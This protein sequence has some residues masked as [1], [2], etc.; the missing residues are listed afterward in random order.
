MNIA[1]NFTKFRNLSYQ[2]MI[3]RQFFFTPARF[4]FSE[5]L[6]LRNKNISMIFYISTAP[7]F[8]TFSLR[9]AEHKWAMKKKLRKKSVDET[10]RPAGEL[11]S[12]ASSGRLREAERSIG[13]LVSIYLQKS[14]SIQPRTS[15]KKFARSPYTDRPGP[16]VEGCG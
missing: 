7:G 12:P 2:A 4:E 1:Q 6:T 16:S 15:L 5:I 10:F 9:L 13:L 3:F 14:A 11:R 8:L